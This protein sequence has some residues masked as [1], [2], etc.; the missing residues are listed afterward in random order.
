MRGRAWSAHAQCWLKPYDLKARPCAGRMDR[1]HLIPQQLLKRE[2]HDDACGDPRSWIPACRLH[3]SNFDNRSGVIVPWSALPRSFI[4]LVTELGLMHW[5][6]RRYGP[7][8][9]AGDLVAG[10]DREA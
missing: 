4:D 3:H 10:T 7:P 2:G 1:A 6:E 5:T 8:L 9:V